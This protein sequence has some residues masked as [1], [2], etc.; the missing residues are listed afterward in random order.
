VTNLRTLATILTISLFAA[1]QSAASNSLLESLVSTLRQARALPEGTPT[2]NRCPKDKDVLVGLSRRSI[3][4]ALGEPDWTDRTGEVWY[5][6]GS[7]V[8]QYQVGG[9]FPELGFLYS[10]RGRVSRVTCWYAR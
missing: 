4:R 8:P 1:N 3:E 9:D 2:N 6:F 7:P 10:K 5:F